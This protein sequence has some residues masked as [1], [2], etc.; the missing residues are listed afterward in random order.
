MS[1]DERNSYS[2]ALQT[3]AESLE[4]AKRELGGYVAK[5]AMLSYPNQSDTNYEALVELL[6]RLD[7]GGDGFY[8]P[9]QETMRVLASGRT[10]D[11]FDYIVERATLYP[12]NVN[13]D[14]RPFRTAEPRLHIHQVL[15][16]LLQLLQM[17]RRQIMIADYMASAQTI[18]Q[19]H[20]ISAVL[21]DCIAYTLDRA[22][23]GTLETLREIIYGENQAGL[24]TNQMLKGI[25]MSDQ[26]DA[27]EM[28]GE[29]LVAARLQ[30][31]LRQ[32]IVERM[33]EGTLEAYRYMLDILIRKD[34]IRYSSVVRALGVW[35]GM[36]LE[37]ANQRVAGQLLAQ[38]HEALASEETRTA[39]LQESH[40]NKL[41]IGLWATAVRE[42]ADMVGHVMAIMSEGSK[43]QK[44]VAQ[45]VL[46]NSQNIFVRLHAARS[47]LTERDPELMHGIIRNYAVGYHYDWSYDSSKPQKIR[48]VS[49]PELESKAA[50]SLDYGQFCEML[51][52]LPPSGAG[53]PSHVL[54]FVH[55]RIDAD[56]IV[57]KM[58]YLIAYD[59]DA[60]WI[61]DVIAVKDR[62]SPDIR[63]ELLR[64]FAKYASD[65][66]QRQF[67]Y[68]CLSDKSM[69]IREAALDS[70]KALS[71]TDAE[72]QQLEALL[73]LKTGSLRQKIIQVLLEQ[74]VELAAVA[75]ERL[76]LSKSELQRLGALELL[77]EIAA[78]AGRA[79]DYERLQP[80]TACLAAPTAKERQLLDKL[81][82][83]EE[84]YTAANGYGLFDP[85]YVSPL[86]TETR[87]LETRDA[88]GFF[89]LPLARAEQFLQGLDKLVHEHREHEYTVEYYAGYRDTL[90]VGARLVS[91]MPYKQREGLAQMEQFPLAEV[92]QD[93]MTRSDFSSQELMQL[94]FALVLL[95]GLE[96]NLNHY[97]QLYRSEY[98]YEER[99]RIPLL[100]GWRK[101][102][103]EQLYPLAYIQELRALEAKLNYAAQARSLLI[104][105]YLDSPS[106]DTFGTAELTW[107]SLLASLPEEKLVTDGAYIQLL[108][109]PWR[110]LAYNRVSDDDSFRRYFATAYRHSAMF[111][112]DD[113]HLLL[114][115]ED[116]LRAYKLELV[117]EQEM[118]RELLLDEARYRYISDLTSTHRDVIGDDP[119]LQAL[120]Q[121]VL[122]RILEIELTR[123]EL[124]TEVSSLAMRLGRVHGMTHWVRLVS[125]MDQDTFV[126]GY[127]YG[128]G[129]QPTRKETFSHLIRICHP[130]SGEDGPALARLLEQYPV[131]ERKLLE[132]AMYAPQ[133]LELVAGHLGWQGLRSAA[134][135][136]HA[137]INESFSAEKETVVAHYSPITPQ[138]FNDGAFDIRWFREAYAE[139]GEERFELL[140]DCAKYISGGAN[141][142]R[143][144]LFADATLG[145]LELTDI[146]ESVAAKR[147]KDQLLTYSLI[148]LADPPERDL[149]ERYDFI[150]EFLRQ[151][152]QYG[153]Q[154]RASE[155]TAGQI[156]LGNL[157]R[158]GGYADVTRMVW[159]MEA[160]KLEELS[161]YL[162]FHEIEEGLLVKLEV[163]SQGQTALVAHKNNKPLKSVPSRLNKHEYIVRLKELKSE[164]TEQYRRARAELERSMVNGT[165]FTVGELAAL[166]RNPVLAPLTSA[167]VYTR[168][169][170]MG[171][172]NAEQL[173]LHAPRL[174]EDGAELEYIRY[175]LREE[176]ELTIAH[177]VHLYEQGEWSLFQRDRMERH[178]YAGQRDRADQ[179]RLEPFKQVFRELYRPNADELASGIVS[180]RYAGY[181]IQPQKAAA[182]LKGRQWT[183]SYEEGLQKVSYEH[184]L[185][186]SLYALADWF[187]P[188][189]TE[190]PTLETVQFHDRRT[191]EPVKL[192]DVPPVFFSEVMRDIDLVVSVAYVGG[193]DP[194]ASLTTI[195][196]RRV[197][198]EEAMRLM[199]HANVR[200]E[201]N[202]AHIAGRLGEYAV[203]LGSAQAFRQAS[204]ALHIVPVHSQHRGHLLL[205][206]LDE[207]PKT[208]EILSKIILLAEDHKIKD[209]QITGQLRN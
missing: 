124:V 62:L 104:A 200:L 12:Y 81:T 162:E 80:L 37:S 199:K 161:G 109:K 87:E 172:F 5:L 152:K 122:D 177:P 155:G 208:A 187:S 153:A 189:D 186:A 19:I 79:A 42:E 156:A 31:G 147:N 56:D 101:T 139:L 149:R 181:Q 47:S 6:R 133:W 171:Y 119:K 183:V 16:K 96:G 70:I 194:E 3:K 30:E 115:L 71:L 154:R 36:A 43:H 51:A 203:H 25:F 121:T 58:L 190:A 65:E 94:Y 73:K 196:M 202:Y 52:A 141:H 53:G 103:A 95:P 182:L 195:E 60:D 8:R 118:Y 82:R 192:A 145:R 33:D 170:A 136:F 45:Y 38:A 49:V 69:T 28:V 40:A 66:R 180:R 165:T 2:E 67:I 157:A 143:S 131:P 107:A 21:P 14:R 78:D 167:L 18:E 89:T 57:R 137:H 64:Y 11:V 164:L 138:E 72:L 201:G 209:P 111:K 176:Q 9:L 44:V 76:L 166:S 206:F 204:G 197:I 100:E 29:L 159:Q 188:S 68:D 24:L 77:T 178:Y 140:Y 84:A 185:I 126:R 97:Y 160:S 41:Y 169:D 174:G 132:A 27:Y 55:Y 61:A 142:R 46:A 98:T 148:P 1:Q 144:Q 191:Y 193:V 135:Y 22:E 150:Q 102:Y 26:T 50:R 113:W 130:A 4:G 173:C 48:Y 83:E 13:Y 23:E 117:G 39:W 129:D 85:S 146:R 134:W 92:W 59:M 17:E 108:L 123:G 112:G 168:G 175:A 116:F 93:Y 198:V 114:S 184:N 86:L 10:A 74:P 91:T 99:G 75:V 88:H 90:L 63:S 32:S 7:D 125:A 127:I 105:A 54:E 179:Q 106:P 20:E 15:S 158:N 110:D 120:R 34:L 128:S 35:T 151:S 207:D 163:D 205:P